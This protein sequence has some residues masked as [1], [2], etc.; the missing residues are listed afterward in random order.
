MNDRFGR[1]RGVPGGGPAAPRGRSRP[2]VDDEAGEGE[3]DEEPEDDRASY[4]RPRPGTPPRRRPAGG[5]VP[6]RRAGG[7][8]SL[9]G[10]RRSAPRP[11]RREE[12]DWEGIEEE[13]YD[14]RASGR[15]QTW[16]RDA[17][18]D[19]EGPPRRRPAPPRKAT[20]RGRT[21]LLD[22]CTPIFAYAAILPRQAGGIHPG[23]QQFRNEVLAALQKIET[24]A[25]EHGID[26]ED[27]REARYA[28]ALFMDEQVADSE[29]S[30][31][32][33]WSAEPLNIVLLNDPEGGVN[34]FN[35]LEALGERQKALKKVF[36]VCL[37]L[38][39][40]GKYADLEPSQQAAR[41]GEIRQRILR[42]IQEPLENQEVLFPEGYVPAVPLE[43]QAPPPPRW[44]MIASLGTVVT[45]FLLWLVLFWTAGFK[46]DPADQKVRT[47]L[48]RIAEPAAERLQE[49]G[50][51]ET[52][53]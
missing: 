2:F 11:R 23:Y 9:F 6:P 7:S 52:G 5:R 29:W 37:A 40:R 16:E 45:L 10:G 30:G 46:P 4:G 27:A 44:W 36:L 39:F 51:E 48:Q 32:S 43:G 1:N 53:S 24:E 21:T 8:W 35:H 12:F 19:E 49:P 13:E 42:N 22:L 18:D 20:R 15:D 28:L 31:K 47:L 33:Q 34:F 17:Y 41:I 14:E 26:K 25:P 38:G 3:Y 50:S